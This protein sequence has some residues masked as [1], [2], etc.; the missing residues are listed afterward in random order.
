[1]KAIARPTNSSWR[2]PLLVV[3]LTSTVLLGLL[4]FSPYG[5]DFYIFI[6]APILFTLLFTFLITA[7]SSREAR[8]VFAGLL[9]FAGVLAASWILLINQNVLRPELRWFFR[10]RHYKAALLSQPNKAN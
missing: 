6:V 9:T 3:F 1:M 2:I 4:L 5:D 8:L 7:A 10:S